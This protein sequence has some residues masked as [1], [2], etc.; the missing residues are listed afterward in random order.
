MPANHEHIPTPDMARMWSHLEPIANYLEPFSS[1]EIGL[2]IGYN[3]P[4]A[5]APSEVIASL[6]DDPY[7]QRT[8]LGWSIVGVFDHGQCENDEIGFSHRVLCREVPSPLKD[9]GPRATPVMFSV[10][11]SVKEVVSNEVLSILEH[12]FNDSVQSGTALSE[13]ERTFLSILSQ[14]ISFKNGHYKMPLPF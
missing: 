2:L 12:D 5:L 3:C 14:N 9:E 8:D 7:E 4:R 10:R 6:E 13:Q 1:C 11:T